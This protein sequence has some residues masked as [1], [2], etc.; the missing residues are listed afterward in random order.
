[1]GELA[2]LMADNTFLPHC[3]C[4]SPKKEYAEKSRFIFVH[5]FAYLAML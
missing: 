3:K 1:V 2:Q 4:Y 5:H